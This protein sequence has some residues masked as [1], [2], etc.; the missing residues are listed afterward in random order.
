M[1]KMDEGK[2]EIQAYSY[3]ISHESKW[4][5]I[6]NVVDDTVMAW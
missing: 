5:S 3:E 1:K 2:W 4:H 6:G